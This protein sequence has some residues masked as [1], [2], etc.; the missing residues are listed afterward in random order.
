MTVEE[1]LFDLMERTRADL[2]RLESKTDE[3][4]KL[5][6]DLTALIDFIPNPIVR[7]VVR[8]KISRP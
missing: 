3:L 8:S 1:Q 5:R 7:K 4:L 2:R 6:S